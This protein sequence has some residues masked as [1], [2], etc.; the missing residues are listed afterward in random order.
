MAGDYLSSNVLGGARVFL[1]HQ[2]KCLTFLVPEGRL[3]KG[4]AGAYRTKEG[5]LHRSHCERRG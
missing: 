3:S 2:R 5:M 4:G 1:L